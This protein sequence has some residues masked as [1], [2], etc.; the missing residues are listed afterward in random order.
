ML[1]LGR[2]AGF[3]IASYGAAIVVMGGLVVRAILLHRRAVAALK[4]LSAHEGRAK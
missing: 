3:I 1:D 4:A 2:H